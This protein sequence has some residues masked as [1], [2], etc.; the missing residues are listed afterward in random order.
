MPKLCPYYVQEPG[1]LISNGVLSSVYT[2][3]IFT[4]CCLH[5]TSAM[6]NLNSWPRYSIVLY[7][8]YYTA[9][10]HIGKFH[11]TILFVKPFLLNKFCTTKSIAKVFLLIIHIESI[12]WDSFLLFYTTAKI[13]DS[14]DKISQL[15]IIREY[16]LKWV[17]NSVQLFSISGCFNKIWK[18]FGPNSFDVNF[19]VE[20]FLSTIAKC[21]KCLL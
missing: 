18:V 5:K 21:M 17:H 6:N 1:N 20:I 3:C 16:M 4:Q 11:K 12:Y 15:A 8:Y 13:P 14:N 7:V 2:L 19:H 10:L 9:I